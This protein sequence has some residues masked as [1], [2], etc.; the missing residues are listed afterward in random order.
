M[1]FFQPE[2]YPDQQQK[3]V[4]LEDIN[5][6]TEA[7]WQTP[8]TVRRIITRLNSGDVVVAYFNEYPEM[9]EGCALVEDHGS[10]ECL[11]RIWD[12]ISSED[13]PLSIRVRVIEPEMVAAVN[14]VPADVCIDIETDGLFSLG[15]KIRLD[16]LDGNFKDVYLDGFLDGIGSVETSAG[17]RLFVRLTGLLEDLRNERGLI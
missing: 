1:E 17:E 8:E 13:D 14:V 5:A 11:L 15:D 7:F 16:Y 6:Q 9:A 12:P 3:D 10:S 4:S 2:F